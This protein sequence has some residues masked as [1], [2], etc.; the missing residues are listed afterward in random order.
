MSPNFLVINDEPVSLEQALSYLQS[1]GTFQNFL[2][3]ILR[4]HV[5]TQMLKQEPDLQPTVAAIE[6]YLEQ[7]FENNQIYESQP[8]QY[9]EQFLKDNQ[10]YTVEQLQQWLEDNHLAYEQFLERIIRTQ[11]WQN[12]VDHISRP[13][14]HEYFIKHKQK[15]DKV[16]LSC[17]VVDQET[18]AEELR[19]Q[20]KAGESF[21]QLAQDYSIAENRMHGGQMEP[22]SPSDL[23]DEIRIAID[24]NPQS[25]SLI[26]PIDLQNRWYL[27]RLEAILPSALEGEIEAQLKAEIYQEWLSQEMATMNVKMQVTQWLSLKTSTP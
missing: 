23:P 20:I 19:D 8:F 11:T 22:V 17:I 18:L 13:R 9:L 14:L 21:E 7:C 5:I 2:A 10:I 24:K 25:G 12:L 15:L 27:L 4:Q 3:S 26:G 6:Q 1:D 16:L